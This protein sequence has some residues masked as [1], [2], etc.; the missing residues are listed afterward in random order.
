MSSLGNIWKSG[1]GMIRK[2]LSNQ[3]HG[4]WLESLRNDFGSFLHQSFKLLNG[5]YHYH[6]NWH[7]ELMAEYLQL[8][9][10][11]ELTRLI[12]NMPPR[13]LK[14]VCVSVAWP[15]W[16][17]G[18]KPDRRLIVASYAH[19]LSLKHSLDCRHLL[20]SDWYHAA[21]PHTKLAQ[22]QNEKH[23]FA[24]TQHGFRLATS[25]GGAVTGE[26]GDIL[27]M[28]DPLNP[29]QAESESMRTLVNSWFEHTFSS[30]LNDKRRGGIV[31]VMQRLH[32][33]DLAGFLQ[34]KGNWE[35]LELPAIAPATQY[36]ICRNM[37]YRR[38][39]DSALH[40]LREDRAMLERVRR[41]MGS[42]IFEAQYQQNPLQR[43]G[44]LVKQEWFTRYVP[45]SRQQWQMLREKEGVEVVQSWDTA[46]KTGSQHDPSVCLTF[47]CWQGQYYLL[48]AMVER[49]EYPELRRKVPQLAEVWQ[50]HAIVM[51]DKASGQSLLQDL[52]QHS[53]LPLIAWQPQQDKLTRFA[54]VTPVI[55]AGRLVLPQRAAWLA[56][57]EGEVI[58]FPHSRHDD[59]VDALS[60]FL[61]WMQLRCYGGDAR[62]RRL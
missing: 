8:V 52:R 28:D 19:S 53:H 47:A 43:E 56:A 3:I 20:Q 61:G 45:L 42:H 29:L 35:L 57:F 34:R 2:Y 51:E 62:V 38:L 39:R 13:Y 49:L 17:L 60:Q 27:I 31:L 30:R 24:T 41:E 59:Q 23:K 21:Y 33:D 18:Q 16:L 6:S 44:G 15:A 5:G 50:A 4:I 1:V 46:I 58:R 37:H 54:A 40:E 10:S 9:E 11:G 55:E 14:S 25:V 26:G 12:I 36:Y 48:D 32:P 7:L 22:G